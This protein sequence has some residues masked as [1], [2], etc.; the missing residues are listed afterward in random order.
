MDAR[1]GSPTY[2]RWFSIELS[3]ENDKHLLIPEGFL[4]GFVTHEPDTEI[5]YK[6]LDY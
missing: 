5:I 4:H 6:C 2:G 1:C 3:I